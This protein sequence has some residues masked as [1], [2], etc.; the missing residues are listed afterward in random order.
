M[1]GSLHALG[2]LALGIAAAHG[3]TLSTDGGIP[4]CQPDVSPTLQIDTQAFPNGVVTTAGAC[5]QVHCSAPVGNG[6]RLWEGDMTSQDMKDHCE[7][8]LELDDG[9]RMSRE[10]QATPWCGAPQTQ[11]VSF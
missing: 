5:T 11:R 9:R 4:A 2:A 7:I 6:C 8:F 3:C 1:G 10:V